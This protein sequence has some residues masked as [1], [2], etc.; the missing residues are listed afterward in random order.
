MSST[1]QNETVTI[2]ST[3]RTALQQAGYG[4]YMTYAQPVIAALTARE[5][6]ATEALIGKAN[7]LD[8]DEDE[9]RDAIKATGLSVKDPE[10]EPEDADP[11]F[12]DADKV[13]DRN[14]GALDR[15]EASLSRLTA[16]VSSLTDFARRNGYRG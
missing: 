9:V 3:V 16:T 2:E 4:S 12:M 5:Q 10:P 11:M 1:T 7:D 13:D 6:A 8:L 14:T 15:I